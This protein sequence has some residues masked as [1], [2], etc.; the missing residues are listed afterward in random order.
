MVGS[1]DVNEAFR[2]LAKSDL[3]HEY[4]LFDNDR[5]I[6]LDSIIG[7]DLMPTFDDTHKPTFSN[8]SPTRLYTFRIP[9]LRKS[10]KNPRITDGWY[11]L[12]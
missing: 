10:A 2:Q 1:E 8:D 7:H 6:T 4:Y 3:Q 11:Q 5:G 12:T 9:S